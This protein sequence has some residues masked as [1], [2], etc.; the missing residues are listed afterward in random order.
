MNEKDITKICAKLKTITRRQILF[1]DIKIE[2]LDV[3]RAKHQSGTVF[4]QHHHPWFEFNYLT[5]GSFRTEM[6][7]IDF[8]CRKGQALLIPPGVEHTQSSTENGDDGIC[9]RWQ[10]AAAKNE[11]SEKS[12]RFLETVNSPRA[13]SLHVNMNILHNLGEEDLLNDAVFL[14]FLLSIYENWQNNAEKSEPPQLVSHQAILYMEEYLQN[15]IGAS[16]VAHALNMSHR[17]LSRIFKKETGISI[18]E[19]LHELR[20]NK[21]CRL[22]CKTELSI[23]EIA[24]ETGFENIYYFSTTFKKATGNSPKQFRELHLKNQT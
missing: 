20:I 12:M 23:S 18:T 13:E 15:R 6:N 22:L 3:F 8:V 19:K 7:G 14:H 10:I 1:H 17:T 21:A 24:E 11:I 5:D 4:Q 16:D 9:L 2:L